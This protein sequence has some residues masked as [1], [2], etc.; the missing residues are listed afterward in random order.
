MFLIEREGGAS[1]ALAASSKLRSRWVSPAPC[2]TLSGQ[3]LLK[4]RR[5]GGLTVIQGFLRS[6]KDSYESQGTLELSREC[7]GSL[8][9]FLGIRS[10][11]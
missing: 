7:S 8:G 11:F 4:H 3:L 1:E 2:Y 5:A 6:T 10:N 9:I